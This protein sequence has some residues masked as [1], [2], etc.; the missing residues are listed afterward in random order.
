MFGPL[1][2]QYAKAAPFCVMARLI[3]ACFLRPTRLDKLFAKVAKVQY[4]REL[5]FSQ[6]IGLMSKVVFDIYPSVRAAYVRCGH[7]LDV[8]DQA[9]YDKINHTEL[10]L[11]AALVEDSGLQ[12]QQLIRCLG[13]TEK[14]WLPGYRSTILDGNRMSATER[15]LKP[16]QEEWTRGLPGLALVVLDQ[17]TRLVRHVLLN[18]DGHSS[19]RALFDQ[20]YPLVREKDLI[21]ADRNFCTIAMMANIQERKAFFVFR[22]HGSIKG[23]LMGERRLIGRSATG[24]VYEQEIHVKN[25]KTVLKLR[26]ITIVLDEPTREKETEIHLLTNLPVEDADALLVAGLYLGRWG[27]EHLFLDMSKTMNAEPKNLANPKAALLAFCLG[28]VAS[29]AYQVMM[30]AVR[31]EHGPQALDKLSVYYM[32]LEIQK[33]YQGMMIAL[34]AAQWQ[35]ASEYTP[36]ELALKLREIAK[37]IDFTLYP[38]SKRGPKK[39]FER[40]RYRNGHHRSTAKLLNERRQQRKTARQQQRQQ[41]RKMA[42]RKTKRC[43]A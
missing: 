12:A 4:T 22:H 13:A 18:E 16:L 40:K 39:K 2:N 34:P 24:M 1:F 41:H 14:P 10:A 20:F 5:L 38:K 42:R 25:K 15:R 37:T 33:V 7:L 26:R 29:N 28:L 19:E 31:A 9:V 36:E 21:I 11:A 30:S 6:L 27:I 35:A 43:K 3:L 17:E 8:S 32:A 23:E